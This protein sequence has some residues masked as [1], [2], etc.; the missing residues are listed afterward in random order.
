MN[1]ILEVDFSDDDDEIHTAMLKL[2]ML[3]MF[4]NVNHVIIYTTDGVGG[5]RCFKVD[6]MRLVDELEKYTVNDFKITFKAKEFVSYNRGIQGHSS[7]CT[8]LSEFC[9]SSEQQIDIGRKLDEKD[10]HI[11]L[12][13]NKVKNEATKEDNVTISKIDRKN[14]MFLEEWNIRNAWKIG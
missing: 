10:W 6:I 5:R 14:N 9:D 12:E 11:A 2:E 4:K 3:K 8:W 13:T 7:Q 1:L